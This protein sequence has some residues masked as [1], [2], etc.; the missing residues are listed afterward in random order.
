[1]LIEEAIKKMSI[2]QKLEGG[3]AFIIVGGWLLFV[4][5]WDFAYSGG[6]SHHYINGIDLSLTL[7]LPLI[8]G[9]IL[10]GGVALLVT[11]MSGRGCVIA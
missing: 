6:F 3:I 11:Y 8:G 2:K 9:F 10:A 7:M 1:V 4:R 5:L